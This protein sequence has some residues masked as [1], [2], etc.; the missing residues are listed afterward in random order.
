MKKNPDH[1][2]QTDAQNSD[3]N[4]E[5]LIALINKTACLAAENPEI[6]AFLLSHAERAKQT[7]VLE[8][9][10]KFKFSDV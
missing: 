5:S 10:E 2:G 6:F 7:H 8:M 1:S 4:L 3:V 9:R